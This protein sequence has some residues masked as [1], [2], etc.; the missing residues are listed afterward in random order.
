MAKNIAQPNNRPVRNLT[1]FSAS[2][3]C[4]DNL[5]ASAKRP[6]TLISSTVINDRSKK[7]FVGADEM[8]L[9]AVNHMNI[10]SGAYI[11][12]DQSF[13][14]DFG[15]L[16][17]LSPTENQ[18]K[19][20]FY[21]RGAIT[22]V[23]NNTLN[24]NANVDLDFTDA[25]HP[26]TV[27]GGALKNI[28]PS[29]SKGVSIVSVDLHLVSYPD[30]TVL[31]GG[32]VANSMVVTNKTFGVGASGLINLTGYD[33]SFSFNRVES[34]GQAV[35]NLIELGT[36]EL[37]GRHAKVPYWQCLNIEP[38]NEKLENNKR[39]KFITTPK[40]ISISESQ[41]ML[42]KLGY[43]VGIANGRM[44]METHRAISKFQ[45]DKDLIATG[46]LNYDV[47]TRLKQE[48]KGYPVNGFTHSNKKHSHAN[49]YSANKTSTTN[50][51]G[52]QHLTLKSAKADYRL[53]DLFTVDLKARTSGYLFCFHQSGN[54]D[55]LQILPKD[56]NVQLQISGHYS[57]KL[58]NN[59]DGFEIK[60][61]HINKAERI[62]CT[63]HD[64]KGNMASPFAGKF[65]TFARLPVKQLEEIPEIF[66]RY[67]KIKDWVMISKQ[68]NQ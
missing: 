21:F 37:L 29:F 20:K 54:G 43:Y 30:K 65:K 62:M 26:I 11:F 15:Q 52:K 31:P 68:V 48:F 34:I 9:N 67:G 51:N 38:T 14:K 57:R 17:L 63:L 4:M 16:I 27:N 5:L 28:S 24:D 22:Q 60:F 35:R 47:Y 46:D 66:A 42:I 55:V 41:K 1:S 8:L 23:D 56:P 64:I 50:K 36:I 40:P 13:S 3:R 61:E 12:L 6:R 58:P 7:T 44:N 59:N 49:G 19:P 32:S 25:P 18:E 53:N 10:K 33:M 39:T 2:L 45:A